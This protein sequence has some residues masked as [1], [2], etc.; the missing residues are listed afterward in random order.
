MLDRRAH[1][2]MIASPM[3]LSSVPA[4]LEDDLHHLGEVFVKE[5]GDFVRAHLLDIVVKPRMSLKNTTTFFLSSAK[6]WPPPSAAICSRQRAKRTARIGADN[7]SRR[8][9]SARLLFS[10]ATAAIPRRR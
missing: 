10:K 9:R 6:R 1:R 2:A 4:V 5:L 8:T 7:A 3:N